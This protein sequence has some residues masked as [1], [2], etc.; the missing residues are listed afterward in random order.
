MNTLI[1]TSNER[2]FSKLLDEWMVFKNGEVKESTYVHYKNLIKNHIK[3]QIGELE[4]AKIDNF[5]LDMY[6]K[7]QLSKG[8]V[9]GKGGIA[10][11][12]VAD[13]RSVL[14]QVI[15]YAHRHGELQDV[16]TEIYF[17]KQEHHAVQILSRY[18]QEVLETYLVENPTPL[19]LS[20]LLTLYTGIRIGEL[21]A[22]QWKDISFQ[23]DTLTVSKTMI[24]IQNPSE[25]QDKKTQVHV[26]SPKTHNSFRTIP[27][28]K[29][30]TELLRT[31]QLE[32]NCYLLTGTD[33]WVEPRNCLIKYKKILKGLSLPNFTF[34]ALRHTFATRCVEVGVDVKSLSEILGHATVNITMQRYVHPTLEQKRIQME[35]MA[36][37]C[38][39]KYNSIS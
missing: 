7:K 20:I 34:H 38:L 39:K 8:R 25:T 5:V 27:L 2:T 33:K 6:L 11:K 18:E 22:L 12:T 31:F 4:L 19:H 32:G 36:A 15:K 23:N 9:D 10:P 14:I 24:R 37:Y 21:C 1:K 29:A 28:P 26:T 35:K 17:P 13:L 16:A 3:P 30:I